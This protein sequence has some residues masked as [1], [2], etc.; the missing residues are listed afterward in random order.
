MAIGDPI[1]GFTLTRSAERFAPEPGPAPHREDRSA[2]RLQASTPAP[3]EEIADVAEPDEGSHET[4]FDYAAA[5]ADNVVELTKLVA[6]IKA[7]RKRHIEA[8][9]D[10]G[11]ALLR[12]K[13]LLGHGNFL[14]WLQA[15]FR[16][17]E[18]TANNYM[19]IARFFRGKTA[20]FA[21][22]DIGAASALAAKSTPPDIRDELLE[23]AEAG[24]NISR[25]EVKMRI[26]AGK[27]ARRLAQAAA[28][29]AA[30][31]EA[32]ATDRDD[33]PFA[34]PFVTKSRADLDDLVWPAPALPQI[35]SGAPIEGAETAPATSDSGARTIIEAVLRIES[36]MERICS[37]SPGEAANMLLAAANEQ[38]LAKVQ[39]IIGLIIEIKRALDDH[40]GIERIEMKGSDIFQPAQRPLA[41]GMNAEF[42]S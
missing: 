27:K 12:A 11:A 42:A 34:P 13:E 32:A 26:A 10:V 1:L 7:S 40:D 21:D 16:W 19:S 28:R 31:S 20:N 33:E 41:T 37:G 25:E 14:P 39:K 23:R 29:Q 18:R 24:E 9:H 4:H 35:C 15:E 36:L 30:L 3:A 17:S 22:L 8:V 5:P 38:E 2:L 6:R